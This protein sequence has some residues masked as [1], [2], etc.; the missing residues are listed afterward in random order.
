MSEQKSTSEATSEERQ[1]SQLTR[2]QFLTLAGTASAAALLAACAPG[3]TTAPS[4]PGGT[5]VATALPQ[6]STGGGELSYLHWT[7]FVPEMDAKLDEL[8]KKWGDSNKVNVK[9]EHI[10]IND[11]PARR[12][13]AIQAKAGPDLIWDTQNWPQSFADTLVDVSD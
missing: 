4:G 6:V 10:N 12:A 13:A 9:V 7:N 1:G 2:R 11:V 5:P 3:A 8:A